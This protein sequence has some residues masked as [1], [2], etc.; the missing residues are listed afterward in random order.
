MMVT[1]LYSLLRSLIKSVFV[2]ILVFGGGFAKKSFVDKDSPGVAQY[3]TSYNDADPDG[4]Y[5]L[6][7]SDEFEVSGRTFDDGDDARWTALDKEDSFEFF[8]FW[9]EIDLSH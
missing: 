8:D 1:D 2:L 6:V 9:I 3:T 7:L 4:I 5:K